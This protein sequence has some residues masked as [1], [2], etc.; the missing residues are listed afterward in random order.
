MKLN[1]N[2]V[3]WEIKWSWKGPTDLDGYH[4]APGARGVKSPAEVFEQST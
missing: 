4:V 1:L 3:H 2:V